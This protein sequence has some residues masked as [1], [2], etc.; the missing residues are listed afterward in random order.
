MEH[1]L[2]VYASRVCPDSVA[3]FLG[4]CGVNNEESSGTLTQ[5]TWLLWRF[6]GE[7]TLATYMRRRDTISALA[8]DLKVEESDVARTVLKQI[9]LNLQGLHKAGLVHRDVKPSNLV[10]CENDRTFKFIDLGACADLRLGTNYVP[11][12]SILD[13]IYCPPEQYVL[14]TDAPHLSK[15][16]LAMVISPML[17]SKHKPDRFD[18]Y[19]AG[20]I[21][22]Q[23]AVPTMCSDRAIRAFT[24]RY[25]SYGYDLEKWRNG[26]KLIARHTEV[27]DA[28]DGAGWKLL[29]EMLKPREIQKSSDGSI[30]FMESSDGSLRISTDAALSHEFFTLASQT[31]PA[32]MMSLWQKYTRK[33]FDLEG[34]ILDQVVET[35]QQTTTVKKLRSQVEKGEASKE[36]LVQEEEKLDRIQTSLLGVTQDFLKTTKTAFQKFGV[37]KQVDEASKEIIQSVDD[38]SDEEPAASTDQKKP[39]SKPMFSWFRMKP[40]AEPKSAPEAKTEVEE[41]TKET[42]ETEVP[43]AAE[44]LVYMGLRFTGLAA[45]VASD[46]AKSVRYDAEKLMEEI[47]QESST[48]K[49]NNIND[50][51]FLELLKESNVNLKSKLD[52]ISAKFGKDERFKAIDENRRMILFSAYLDALKAKHE[53]NQKQAKEDLRTLFIDMDVNKDSQWDQICQDLSGDVVF[54]TVEDPVV[55]KKIFKEVLTTQAKAESAH[56][57][58]IKA[59]S[60]FKVLLKELKDPAIS[61]ISSWPRVKRQIFDDP[62]YHEVPEGRRQELFEEYRTIIREIEKEEETTR[63]AELKAL[64]DR[65]SR[66][67][68]AAEKR[69]ESLMS[70]RKRLKEEYEK[71][72][73]NLAAME[74]KLA[75]QRKALVAKQDSIKQT[76]DGRLVLQHSPTEPKKG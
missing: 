27:L 66:E 40:K 62:R 21:F 7:R 49:K 75:S 72:Q 30:S 9:L 20:L 8:Q 22:F 52:S 37:K 43:G 26:S 70:E 56:N 69:L 24:S 45:R 63:I 54:N 4:Y 10:F 2:N 39:T 59:E 33:L 36:E 67:T 73:N 53:Q 32:P 38:T 13:A 64:K 51:K 58:Q 15:N 65:A 57:A 41:K 68:A 42:S 29:G 47:E 76:S 12:E 6:Q 16:V 50:R 34:A 46:L 23:L 25:K 74:S 19:S 5:G 55:R 28:N 11:D 31:K 14:P 61:G 1:V 71:M 17:W 35:E 48:K 60:K 44:N 18:V 3:E